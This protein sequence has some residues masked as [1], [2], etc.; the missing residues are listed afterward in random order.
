MSKHYYLVSVLLAAC[1]CVVTPTRADRVADDFERRKTEMGANGFFAVF[2]GDLSSEERE[3]L[4]FLYAYMP[5]PDLTDYTSNFYRANV[6]VSL[7]AREEMPWGKT[8]P[9]RE[10]RHFVL[11]IRV[12]NEALDSS[13]I[14][15]YDMLKERV[16]HLSMAEAVLEV[17]HWC[18]EHVTY[19]PSDARTSPPLST[20]RTSFGRCGEEST[21]TVA[22]LRAVGIPARQ[23]YTPRW[24]HTD[25]NHA[26]VEAWVDG[27]WHFLGACE[28]EPVLDLGWFNAPASRGML[29]HTNVFGHYDGPEDV[30][31]ETPCYTEINVT[32][33]YAPTSSL[34]VRTVSASG[35]IV[36]ASVEFK[37]YNYAEYYTVARTQSDSQG[38]ARLT[39]G[40]GDL[41]VWASDGEAW[42]WTKC[43][44]GQG[45]TVTIRL[46]KTSSYSGVT[47]WDIHPPVQGDNLPEVTEEQA[48][49]NRQRLAYEDSLRNDYMARTFLSDEEAARLSAT[50][51]T[52]LSA[53]P[54]LLSEAYGNVETLRRFVDGVPAD[55]Q[56]R[57]IAL[58]SVISAKDRRDITAEILDDNFRNT[59]A[60]EGPLY[61][62]Y[63]LNPRV[64]V[65][66][67]TP[68]KAYF[69]KAIPAAEQEEYRN[70]PEQWAEWC[71]QN[72]RVDKT[73]NPLSLCQSPAAVWETRQ[74]DARSRDIF[75]VAAARSMGIP[76]RIDP[77][78]GRTQYADADGVWHDAGLTASDGTGK[79]GD[80]WLVCSFEP[81]AH[82][83]DPKYYTHFT[84]S[85]IEQ[86]SPRLLNYPEEATWS[87]ILKDGAE[88]EAGQYVMTT[89]TRMADGSV[90]ARSTVFS[91]EAGD[92]TRLPLVM[93]ESDDGVQVI[94][95]FN[96]ENLYY[97]IQEGREKSL[98]STTG[99]GYFV[100]GLIT[101]NQEPTNH[102]LRDMAAVADGLKAWGRSLVLL[103][104]DESEAA[105]FKAED[106][107]LPDNVV[108]GIDKTG[109]IANEIKENMKLTNTTRPVF[110]IADTFNRVVFV[111]QGY[112]I[113]LG[114]QLMKVIRQL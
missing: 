60:G 103:F 31:N 99:R 30:V 67:L 18:H 107:D 95:S 42:G 8:V 111:S 34:V 72:I 89:G 96:S 48:A 47:E 16:R 68:Y 97:D 105:R 5:L 64:S 104:D 17:N 24:A 12:N 79:S 39:A 44:V 78:N 69:A 33:H 66:P 55:Q 38:L 59:P 2:D 10:F 27:Q 70:H 81:T 41:I 62:A 21:F 13:R 87:G 76:A 65:E 102:A 109:V 57:A 26:W 37:L 63:V 11:P 14:V 49:H 52:E 100:V 45:D 35:E 50:L 22:A 23:V 29:M 86:G 28:P 92:T 51:P 88:V 1:A 73:W 56:S 84:L 101:P 106:F 75:F 112:T 108:Y 74:T 110:I 94:G 40:R 114:E 77:V 4:Q 36:P 90:L 71:R 6:D 19:R 7:R 98:L 25:D 93:R 3:A 85:K 46:D 83:D 53:L 91:V 113:G 54:R 32:S 61:D 58:L 80:G 15:F 20:L 43:S 82:V 9:E